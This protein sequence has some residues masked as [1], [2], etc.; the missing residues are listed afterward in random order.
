MTDRAANVTDLWPTTGLARRRQLASAIA[1][2][3]RLRQYRPGEWLRQIDLEQRF[4]ATRFD[5]RGALDELVVLKTL[6][7]VPN[8]GYRVAEVDMAI[9]RDIIATRVIIERAAAK[10]VAPRI[11]AAAIEELKQL[12]VRFG[13]A[14]RG[15]GRIEQSAINLEFHRIIYSHCGNPVLEETIWALR[16]RARGTNVTMARSHAALLARDREHGDIIAALE[17]RDGERF[18]DLTEQHIVGD[19]EDVIA[20]DPGEGPPTTVSGRGS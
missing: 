3:I 4:G 18:A 13:Q 2:A 16:D 10:A 8:R 7:H 17:A 20:G 6:E 12:A 5:I 15:S 11:D 1:A 9:Y 19:L 14:V